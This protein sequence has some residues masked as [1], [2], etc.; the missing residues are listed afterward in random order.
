MVASSVIFS[1]AI[2]MSSVLREMAAEGWAIR[3]KDLVVISPQHR[4]NILRFGDYDTDGLH[5]PPSPYNP[6]LNLDDGEA[7]AA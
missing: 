4:A 7:A 2:D 6:A 1:T 5:I 3:P